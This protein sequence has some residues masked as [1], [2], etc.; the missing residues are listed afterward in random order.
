MNH[1][2][3]NESGYNEAPKFGPSDNNPS[4]YMFDKKY[5]L[6]G[7]EFI[8]PI[9]PTYSIPIYENG[10]KTESSVDGII[11]DEKYF[12]LLKLGNGKDLPTMINT[13]TNKK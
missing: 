9:S 2:K 4:M 11:G 12:E 3:I 8:R 6:K 5:D 10:M 7:E 1:N 13:I